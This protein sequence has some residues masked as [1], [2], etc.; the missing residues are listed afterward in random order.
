MEK[1]SAWWGMPS[2]D[3]DSRIIDFCWQCEAAFGAAKAVRLPEDK[4]RLLHDGLM[5]RARGYGQLISLSEAMSA[6]FQ[7]E[8]GTDVFDV[9]WDQKDNRGD[10]S[11]RI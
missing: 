3:G 10:A 8:R 2:S 4:R 9:R 11:E 1:I 5:E 7:I 6:I